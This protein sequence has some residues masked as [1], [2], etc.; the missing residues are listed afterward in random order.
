[1]GPAFEQ[2]G[3]ACSNK[4]NDTEPEQDRQKRVAGIADHLLQ[5]GEGRGVADELEGPNKSGEARIAGAKY[6]GEDSGQ[7]SRQ[8]AD[9]ADRDGPAQLRAPCARILGS[10]CARCRE[11]PQDVFGDEEAA[12]GLEPDIESGRRTLPPRGLGVGKHDANTEGEHDMMRALKHPRAGVGGLGI[13]NSRE[14]LGPHL[15]F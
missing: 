8:V 10:L 7:S 4:H 2:I 5:A 1:M 13:K 3:K 9:A 6:D 12:H 15:T 11:Q 14:A